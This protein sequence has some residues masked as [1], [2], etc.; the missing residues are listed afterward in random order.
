[1]GDARPLSPR[2]EPD[3]PLGPE[4]GSDDPQSNGAAAAEAGSDGL[5]SSGSEDVG[6]DESGQT[7]YEL[8]EWLP[9][10]RAQLGVLL[11]QAG[12]EYEWEHADLVVPSDR[13]EEVEALFAQHRGAARR[14]MKTTTGARARYHAIEELFAATGRLA[15]DPGDEERAAAV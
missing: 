6:D 14:A 5:D 4:S 11:E 10:Q 13:E 15:G 2:S 1:M 8:P 7:V 3:G 12:I 9:E